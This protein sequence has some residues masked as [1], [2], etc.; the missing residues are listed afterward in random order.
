MEPINIV[1]TALKVY[2]T[3]NSSDWST[4]VRRDTCTG[5]KICREFCW[6][7]TL[8]RWRP[9]GLD[10]PPLAGSSGSWPTHPPHRE[11]N[12]FRHTRSTHVELSIQYTYHEIEETSTAF[13]KS[14]FS[15]PWNLC[16]GSRLGLG[17]RVH[18]NFIKST[19]GNSCGQDMPGGE[20]YQ[21][22]KLA[23]CI[24]NMIYWTKSKR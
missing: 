13:Y 9:V 19:S 15:R 6:D 21:W 16:A 24:W 11:P 10:W 14:V 17:W 18:T 12:I 1:K 5:I 22:T 7:G 23:I 20:I 4:D 2:G 3:I 8:V